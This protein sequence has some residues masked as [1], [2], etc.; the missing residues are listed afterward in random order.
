MERR[1]LIMLKAPFYIR[2]IRLILMLI[3]FCFVIM[4]RWNDLFWP[5]IVL[6]SNEMRTMQLA[7]TTLFRTL[8]DTR[9]SELC[10]ALTIAALPVVMLYSVFQKYF[11]KGIVL[12]SGVKG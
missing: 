10:A 9:W 6:N 12:T 1:K 3:V 11:T 7:L 8:H 2:I 5:L 4:A